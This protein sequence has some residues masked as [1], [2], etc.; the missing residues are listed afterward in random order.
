VTQPQRVCLLALPIS[1]G[2]L[3]V[4][5]FTLSVHPVWGVLLLL[6]A[7]GSTLQLAAGLWG[8][9]QFVEVRRRSA[10]GEVAP[11]SKISASL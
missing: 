11:D 7:M 2:A 3:V 1:Y 10:G 6:G 5:L 4:G 9:Q 8:V